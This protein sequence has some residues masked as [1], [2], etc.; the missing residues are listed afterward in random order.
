M[1]DERR[2]TKPTRQ[3]R[4]I[5]ACATVA[6]MLTGKAERGPR[7][8]FFYLNDEGMP[9]GTR[10]GDWKIFFTENRGK[11][12]AL[13]A[14][15]FVTLRR[16]KIFNLR[17]DPYERAQH[18]SN[19][20]WDWM[21]D[22]VPQGYLALAKTAEFLATFKQYPPSQKPD[23]WSIDKITGQMLGEEYRTRLG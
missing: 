21:I 23:S 1:F 22:K 8:V 5:F 2:H 13:W 14:E 20:Y 16:F 4:R 12:R 19:S 15:P 18:S 9:V 7:D 10:V 17:R 3:F 11:T 6:F